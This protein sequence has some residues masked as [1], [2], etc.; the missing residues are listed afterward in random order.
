MMLGTLALLDLQGTSERGR[1]TL[2]LVDSGAF[3][4]DCTAD[5]APYV[6]IVPTK[7][8]IRVATAGNGE[9]LMV[10]GTKK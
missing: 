7:G 1:R 9:M 8:I 10:L 6:P 5:F 3:D 4:H 2:I